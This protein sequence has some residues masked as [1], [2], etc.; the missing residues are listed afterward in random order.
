[1]HS[2]DLVIDTGSTEP[3]QMMRIAGQLRLP[4]V[5]QVMTT[6]AAALQTSRR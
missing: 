5:P 6:L 1:V 2:K 4:D 3:V